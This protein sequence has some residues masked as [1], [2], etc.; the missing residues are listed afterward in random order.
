MNDPYR[1]NQSDETAF[2]DWFTDLNP[3]RQLGVFH[4]L[5]GM[6]KE[7]PSEPQPQPEICDDT[8]IAEVEA[9]KVFSRLIAQEWDSLIMTKEQTQELFNALFGLETLI[10][11]HAD[12]VEQFIYNP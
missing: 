4:R 6:L 10:G 11:V 1:A 9:M 12:H 5:K 3:A 7:P 2:T 8:L